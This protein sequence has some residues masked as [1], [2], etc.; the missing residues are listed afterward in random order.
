MPLVPARIAVLFDLDGTLID[1]SDGIV[2]AVNH[3]LQAV[4]EPPRSAAEILP[5]IGYSLRVMFPHFTTAPYDLLR[6]HFL[7]YADQHLSAATRLL[8][9]ATDTIVHL[10]SSGHVLGIVSTK[11]RLHIEQILS[12]ADWEEYFSVIVGG[13]EVAQVKPAAEPFAL[14]QAR[15]GGIFDIVIV[16]GDTENDI[17]PARSLGLI[18]CAVKSPYVEDGQ[19]W[20]ARV[21]DAQADYYLDTLT[22]LPAVIARLMDGGEKL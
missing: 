15:L 19:R 18:S 8:P 12:A 21:L 3:A 9:H 1:S 16:V 13:D 7:E 17:H 4:G 5:W 11:R 10:A 6:A 22:E 2:A 14:A 20:S